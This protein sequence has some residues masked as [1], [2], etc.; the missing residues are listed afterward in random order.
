MT[1]SLL[2]TF[3]LFFSI[4]SFPY[5]KIIILLSILVIDY[6]NTRY[7]THHN[8]FVFSKTLRKL[9]GY[10]DTVLEAHLNS[11]N[12]VPKVQQSPELKDGII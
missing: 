2:I 6:R 7:S 8:F 1:L 12:I 4:I 11:L 3:T 5:L 10:I 9:C